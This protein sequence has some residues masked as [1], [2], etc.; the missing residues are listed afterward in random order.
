MP[1][2]CFSVLPS[3]WTRRATPPRAVALRAVALRAVG[4]G[5]TQHMLDTHQLAAGA[6]TLLEMQHAT[7]RCSGVEEHHVHTVEGTPESIQV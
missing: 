4:L 5:C 1:L 2:G 3:Q 6:H 7:G